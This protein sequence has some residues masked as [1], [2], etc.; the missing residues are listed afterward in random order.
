MNR[1][2]TD[3]DSSFEN[4]SVAAVLAQRSRADQNALLD[5]LVVMLAEVVPGV[6]VERS[7]LRRQVTAIRLPLGGFVYAL[8]KSSGDSF[9]AARQQEV[10]G[11]VIRTV[12]MEIDAFLTELGLALDVELRRTEKGR[13]ALHAWLN[14]TN[15]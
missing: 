15:P 3:S 6:H 12:P 8:R 9:E 14:S 4:V 7:L 2:T 1:I 5:E 10:R 13:A 11:V